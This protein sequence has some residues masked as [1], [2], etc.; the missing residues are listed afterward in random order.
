MLPV[1]LTIPVISTPDGE[2]TATLGVPAGFTVI[3]PLSNVC[4]VALPL[5]IRVVSMPVKNL[6]LPKK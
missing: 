3:L 4:T 2:N 6:P 1:A 5:L